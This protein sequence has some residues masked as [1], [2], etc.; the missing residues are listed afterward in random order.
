MR[1]SCVLALFM[2]SL[3]SAQPQKSASV[4][5][6]GIVYADE[7]GK[8]TTDERGGFAFVQLHPGRYSLYAEKAGF[9]TETAAEI[10]PG[11]D[12]VVRFKRA[13]TVSGRVIDMDGGALKDVIVEV[14]SRSYAY[15]RVTLVSAG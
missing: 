8:T 15:G 3:G 9:L 10:T 7:V 11:A 4:S 5:F 13:A 2:F 14:T 1:S 12:I 6:H